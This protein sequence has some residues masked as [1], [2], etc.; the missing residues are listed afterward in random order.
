MEA[1]AVVTSRLARIGCRA[2]ALLVGVVT[3]A[4]S[5]PSWACPS[6][7]TRSGGGSL[8]PFLLGAM[9]L[10]PYVVSTVVVRIFRKAEAARAREDEMARSIGVSETS[11]PSHAQSAAGTAPARA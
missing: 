1:A 4:V 8:I 3:F 6:C 7:T 10:T 5:S 11:N 9:I 2:T